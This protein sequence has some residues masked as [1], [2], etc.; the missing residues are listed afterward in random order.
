[1]HKRLIYLETIQSR[2]TGG[3]RGREWE[4]E[5]ERLTL[6]LNILILGGRNQRWDFFLNALDS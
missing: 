4:D 2:G 5:G 3:G 6:L 1:M